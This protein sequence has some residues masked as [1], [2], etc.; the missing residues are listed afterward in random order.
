MVLMDA[1]RYGQGGTCCWHG[2]ASPTVG[3]LVLHLE[4]AR[5]SRGTLFAFDVC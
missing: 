3:I 1:L 4:C 5:L 2:G